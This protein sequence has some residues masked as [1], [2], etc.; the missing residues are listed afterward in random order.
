VPNIV[1][2]LDSWA[3]DLSKISDVLIV[4]YEDLRAEPGEVLQRIL[5]FLGAEASLA[6]AEE[7]VAF[8]RYE[9]MK[10]LEADGAFGR[11]DRRINPGDQANPQSFKTRRGKVGGYR[12]YFTDEE[13]RQIDALVQGTAMRQFGYAEA[14]DAPANPQDLEADASAQ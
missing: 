2:F 13:V 6:E 5:A 10:K 11:H 9:N 7:A 12:D 8:A 14:D 3:R 4:R 1:A